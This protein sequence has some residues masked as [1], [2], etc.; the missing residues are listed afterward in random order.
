MGYD[1]SQMGTDNERY[2]GMMKVGVRKSFFDPIF[3][4][5]RW[6]QY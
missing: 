4:S 3:V 5:E 2:K 1:L 6:E